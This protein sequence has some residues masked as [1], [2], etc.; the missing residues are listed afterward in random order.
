M[1]DKCWAVIRSRIKISDPRRL[2]GGVVLSLHNWGSPKP[3]IQF[4]GISGSQIIGMRKTTF[5]TAG[6]LRVNQQPPIRAP[7]QMDGVWMK[8]MRSVVELTTMVSFVLVSR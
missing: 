3:N 7:N 5:I 2:S 8:K 1:K 4:S 6:S